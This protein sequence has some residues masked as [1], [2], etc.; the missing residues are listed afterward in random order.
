MPICTY[1]TIS[2][3]G[4]KAVVEAANAELAARVTDRINTSLQL[5][6]ALQVP[7]D[8]EIKAGN[9]AGNGRVQALIDSLTAQEQVLFEVFDLFGLSVT[10]PE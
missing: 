10:I 4:V 1:G 7:F 6:N 9:P 5:A 8:Q 3:P 2:G